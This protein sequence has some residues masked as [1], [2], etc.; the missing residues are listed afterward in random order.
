MRT[1]VGEDLSGCYVEGVGVVPGLA[2]G[3]GAGVVAHEH[4]EGAACIVCALV[5]VLARV[6]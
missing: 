2:D 1:D 4:V 6:S 3:G 5:C